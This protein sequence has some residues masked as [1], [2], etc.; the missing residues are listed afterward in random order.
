MGE[1]LSTTNLTMP[2]SMSKKCPNCALGLEDR[3]TR[4]ERLQAD[5]EADVSM[6][7]C[8][9]PLLSAPCKQYVCAR[10][11]LF[12]SCSMTNPLNSITTS[13]LP[14]STNT[15]TPSALI[16]GAI[17][18]MDAATICVVPSPSFP[19]DKDPGDDDE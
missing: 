6:Q 8:R 13:S 1:A 4:C 18:T 16:L 5:D 3:R 2:S 17:S 9:T 19:A 10:L 15:S 14:T 7:M 11:L 12:S